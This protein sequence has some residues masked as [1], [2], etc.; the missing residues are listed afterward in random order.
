MSSFIP[1]GVGLVRRL[2]KKNQAVHLKPSDA[3][4][5]I[6]LRLQM[7]LCEDASTL[8]RFLETKWAEDR[9][10][11]RDGGLVR[12]GLFNADRECLVAHDRVDFQFNSRLRFTPAVFREIRMS[13]FFLDVG[14]CGRAE[15]TS[16]GIEHHDGVLVGHV[17]RD[18]CHRAEVFVAKV[19]AHFP[20]LLH[21][22]LLL[23]DLVDHP[24]GVF[25]FGECGLLQTTA[26]AVIKD[27]QNQGIRIRHFVDA[28][29]RV[30]RPCPVKVAFALTVLALDR[31]A[32]FINRLQNFFGP[33]LL[34]AVRGAKNPLHFLIAANLDCGR[35]VAG[36]N[37][38]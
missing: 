16:G 36:R 3:G 25:L 11:P 7:Q 22:H 6:S 17:L 38:D 23:I 31:L 12:E 26:V 24:A 4:E 9:T 20:E 5:F 32:V 33:A 21:G 37:D 2:Q 8:L 34:P 27:R 10:S 28:V 1:C 13:R 18:A 19:L 15:Q 35:L 14:T 30:L 29:G